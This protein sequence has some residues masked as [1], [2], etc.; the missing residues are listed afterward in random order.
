MPVVNATITNASFVWTLTENVH[1]PA[2]CTRIK[3]GFRFDFQYNSTIGGGGQNLVFQP[4]LSAAVVG[5]ETSNFS[6]ELLNSS[7]LN[8]QTAGGIDAFRWGA[9]LNLPNTY[10]FTAPVSYTISGELYPDGALIPLLSGTNFDGPV[11]LT[12]LGWEIAR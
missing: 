7:V 11:P 10:P 4:Q 6:T 12:V 5:H 3:V 9:W 2:G 8:P 1:F